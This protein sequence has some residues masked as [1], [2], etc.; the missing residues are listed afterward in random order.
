[1]LQADTRMLRSRALMYAALAFG[2]I[3]IL[4]R[5]IQLAREA[6]VFKGSLRVLLELAPRKEGATKRGGKVKAA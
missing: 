2:T 4:V 3:A 1:M 5:R 6:A